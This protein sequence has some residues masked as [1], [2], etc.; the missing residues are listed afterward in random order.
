MSRFIPYLARKTNIVANDTQTESDSDGESDTELHGR[1]ADKK[2]KGKGKGKG[3]SKG[4]AKGK[5]KGS[6]SNKRSVQQ[7]A[8]SDVDMFAELPECQKCNALIKGLMQPV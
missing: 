2:G 8:G 4:K 1:R 6:A 7:L 5:G 3:R